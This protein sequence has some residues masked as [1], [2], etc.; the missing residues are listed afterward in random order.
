MKKSRVRVRVRVW[1]WVVGSALVV[2]NLLLSNLCHNFVARA[3]ASRAN[4]LFAAAASP[5]DDGHSVV[6]WWQKG[7]WQILFFIFILSFLFAAPCLLNVYYE[8]YS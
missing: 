4:S 6:A 1:V 3:R 2:G 8:C 5:L 7:V